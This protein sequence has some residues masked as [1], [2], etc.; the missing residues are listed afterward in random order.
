MRHYIADESI[1]GIEREYVE[2][3]RKADVG[4]YVVHGSAGIYGIF[5]RTDGIFAFVNYDGSYNG[6]DAWYLSKTVT[7]E[8]TD[9]V[10]I[11]GERYRLVN[12]QAEVGEKV[13]IIGIHGE[14]E[15]DTGV[16][17]YSHNDGSISINA[18]DGFGYFP[19]V[20]EE[21]YLVLESLKP[22]EAEPLTVDETQAS[23]QVID[24]LANLARRV[25]QLEEQLRDT[26]RNVETF[27]QLAE[28][29]SED[30][31]LLGERTTCDC[32]SKSGAE[33]LA[34]AFGALTRYEKRG[35]R[36]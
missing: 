15:G 20:Y 25:T 2:V 14:H 22:V 5:E 11:D 23:P 4:D 7:V 10:R 34:E 28:S 26:Q 35:D 21:E 32:T 6:R 29:N 8:P 19:Y 18:G 1:G 24:M 12:R 16:V 31:R 13:L 17:E 30:I 9:I 27:A 3:E 33:L 36:Q